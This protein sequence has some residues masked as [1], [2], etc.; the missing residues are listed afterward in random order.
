[1]GKHTSGPWKA[2]YDGSS[3][4]SIGGADDPQCEPPYVAIDDRND[5]RA[6]AN[7]AL[8]AAAPD[9]LEALEN[10]ENDDGSIPDHAWRICQAAIAKAKGE[11]N[12]QQ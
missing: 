9:L 11:A 7:A 5:D 3:S 12:V 8:I 6:R 1:M 2:V 10:L 4:W